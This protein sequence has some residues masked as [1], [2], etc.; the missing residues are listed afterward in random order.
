[1][2]R[3]T[4]G[5]QKGVQKNHIEKIFGSGTAFGDPWFPTAKELAPSDEPRRHDSPR[6]PLFFYG[7]TP[8]DNRQ[9][10]PTAR[11]ILLLLY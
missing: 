1:M 6:I 2:I 9:G 3:L 7:A 4:I 5:I 11:T 8:C 10:R